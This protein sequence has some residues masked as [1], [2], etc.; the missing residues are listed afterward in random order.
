MER[1]ATVGRDGVC[2]THWP[3][4]WGGGLP[5][6][7]LTVRIGRQR[8]LPV[9][10]LRLLL[11]VRVG[12]TRLRLAVLGALAVLDRLLLAGLGLTLRWALWGW[13]C[14]YGFGWP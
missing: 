4:P 8:L 6:L 10:V 12:L 13:P 11:T 3:C 1:G 14:W 5:V 7:A 2:A 9:R